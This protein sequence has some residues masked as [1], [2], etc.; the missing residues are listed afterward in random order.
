MCRDVA[1][2]DEMG[3]NGTLVLLGMGIIRYWE[4]DA[5]NVQHVEWSRNH[6]QTIVHVVH[7]FLVK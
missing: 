5:A 2:S 7:L 3:Q 6:G 1:R 4:N